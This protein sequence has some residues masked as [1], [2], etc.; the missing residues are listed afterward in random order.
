MESELQ[1]PEFRKNVEDFHP[2]YNSYYKGDEVVVGCD[3]YYD[4]GHNKRHL[5]NATS[6]D[7]NASEKQRCRPTCTSTES[8]QRLCSSLSRKYYILTCY[9]TNYNIPASLCSSAVRFWGQNNNCIGNVS[10]Y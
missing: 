10:I 7:L 8:G 5:I 2:C 6:L 1:N 3:D 9:I 4:N